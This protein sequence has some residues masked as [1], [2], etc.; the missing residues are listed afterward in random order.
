MSGLPLPIW[1]RIS[2]E[3]FNSHVFNLLISK[4]PIDDNVEHKI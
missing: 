3:H 4:G 1:V 2:R